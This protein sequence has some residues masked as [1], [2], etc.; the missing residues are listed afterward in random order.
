MKNSL[1]GIYQYR[2]EGFQMIYNGEIGKYEGVRF[3]EQT[4]IPHG[5]YSSGNYASSSSFTTWTNALSDWIFFLGAD[6]VAEGVAIP[7]EIR[8]KIPD[9]YGRGRGIAW[10][11]L[12]GFGLSHTAAANARIVKWDSSV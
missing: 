11:A 4:N 9:D 3:I 10:Y 6:T 5:I 2:D 12:E 1:E 8:G 7:E